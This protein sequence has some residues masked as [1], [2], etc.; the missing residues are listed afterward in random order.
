MTLAMEPDSTSWS[1][2]TSGRFL[3]SSLYRKINQGPSLPHEKL[4]WKAKLPLKIKIFLWQMAKGKMPASDQIKDG[5]AHW[6]E[7]VPC[8]AKSKHSILF[9]SHVSSPI[10][11][12]LELE[13]PLG[14]SGTKSIRFPD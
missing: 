12:R 4:I 9:S 2:E 3:V 1:F 14:F 7:S 6:M 10:L 11:P 8:V 5:M 13:R